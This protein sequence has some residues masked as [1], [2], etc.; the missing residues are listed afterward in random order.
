MF[1]PP[2]FCALVTEDIL[3]IFAHARIYSAGKLSNSARGGDNFCAPLN[4]RKF[5]GQGKLGARGNEVIL[6]ATVKLNSTSESF[7]ICWG[8]KHTHTHG[9]HRAEGWRGEAAWAESGA[10]Q[11][12]SRD[13]GAPVQPQKQVGVRLGVPL[14]PV[15]VR[16]E[17]GYKLLLPKC[18]LRKSF[19]YKPG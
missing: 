16:Y 12:R 14:T 18:L 6:T 4:D 7:C 15:T 13:V 17:H 10:L 11:L 9:L 1:V 19:P 2:N 5:G 3:H 8:R